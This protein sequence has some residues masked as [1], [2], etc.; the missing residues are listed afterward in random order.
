MSDQIHESIEQMT[1]EATAEPNSSDTNESVEF[2]SETETPAVNPAWDFLEKVPEEFHPHI[3]PRL[4]EWDKNFQ[5]VQQKQAP[6]KE[7]IELG[8]PANDIT[9]ALQL[10]HLWTTNPQALYDYLSN[11]LQVSQGQ[12]KEV[13]KEEENE[14]D[15]SQIP[16]LEKDPRFKGLQEEVGQF[17]QMMEAQR[18]QEAQEEANRVASQ[19]IAE[20]FT[21]AETKYGTLDQNV[22]EKIAKIAIANQDS[23]LVKAAEEYF[24]SWAAPA[25]R[26]SD[27]APSV[28]GGNSGLP[29]QMAAKDLANMSSEDRVNN[30][31]AIMAGMANNE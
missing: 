12:E 16:D 25:K 28:L 21:Q 11:Q 19:Q 26:A 27:S 30:L 7:I 10:R 5:E 31:A 6:Y 2:K 14:Y 23:D 13:E 9:D 29:R 20:Q 1:Q 24:T 17:R 22:R 18:Q 4:S 3:T 8:V 15:I